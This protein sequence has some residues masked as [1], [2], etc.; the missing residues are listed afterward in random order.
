M[1]IRFYYIVM[2]VLLHRNAGLR[3]PADTGDD[4]HGTG[5]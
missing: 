5:A 4:L 3:G 1:M 2:P